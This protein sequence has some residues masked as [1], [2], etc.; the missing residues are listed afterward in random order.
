MIILCISLGDYRG[1]GDFFFLVMY[2]MNVG[3]GAYLFR[4]P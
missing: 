2:P 4:I 3:V 1:V